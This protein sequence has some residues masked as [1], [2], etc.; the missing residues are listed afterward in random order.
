MSDQINHNTPPAST[1]NE[2]ELR[3]TMA[4]LEGKLDVALAQH[5]AKL[6]QHSK[7]LVDLR[8]DVSRIEDAPAPTVE[9]QADHEQRIRA[10]ESKSTV[11]PAGLTGALVTT[12][13]IAGAVIAI[14]DRLTGSN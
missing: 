10:V 1:L 6:E 5:G 9:T 3:V 8:R 13:T 4:R 2:V 12:F 7:E 11:S 14:I